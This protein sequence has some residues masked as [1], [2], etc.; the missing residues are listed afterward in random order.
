MP[1]VFHRQKAAVIPTPRMQG[2][3]T[4][5]FEHHYTTLHYTPPLLGTV[6]YISK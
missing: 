2:P 1:T 4:Q 5:T 3:G 6:L